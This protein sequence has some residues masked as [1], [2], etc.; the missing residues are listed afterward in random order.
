MCDQ[1]FFLGEK[2]GGKEGRL[3]YEEAGG[4]SKSMRSVRPTV[5]MGAM[6]FR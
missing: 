2:K 4:E 1:V 3:D 5:K 6:A